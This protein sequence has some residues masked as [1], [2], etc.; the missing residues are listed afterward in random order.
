MFVLIV[1]F[2]TLMAVIWLLLGKLGLFNKVGNGVFNL[3]NL[4][5][6]EENENGNDKN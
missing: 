6:E 5:K 3:K 1:G 2:L 4:F